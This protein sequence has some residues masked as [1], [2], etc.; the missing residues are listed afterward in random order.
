MMDFQK[1]IRRDLMI[2]Y[3]KESILEQYDKS[4]EIIYRSTLDG[5]YKSNNIEG[6]KLIKI[7]KIFEKDRDLAW[8][9]ISEMLKSE[10]VVI[11]T[12]AAAYCLALDMNI[13]IAKKILREI[14]EDDDN[15]IFGFNAKMTLEVWQKQG[16]LH[17]Y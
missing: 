14:S 17:V 4:G 8:T 15:G 11:K 16:Y 2:K 1:K 5:D 12:K 13:D 6:K 10:N 3:D 9:C 7:F